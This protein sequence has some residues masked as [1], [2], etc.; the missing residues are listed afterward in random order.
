MR[1][2]AFRWKEERRV[3]VRLRLREKQMQEQPQ[4]PVR[5]RLREKQ[6]QEQ[7]QVPVRLRLREKQMQ[8]Q[9]QVLRLRRA[10]SALCFAQDD[11]RVLLLRMDWQGLLMAV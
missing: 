2:I 7:P 5:L 8:E 1:G 9:P 6:M 3:P 11:S 4:V 10:R